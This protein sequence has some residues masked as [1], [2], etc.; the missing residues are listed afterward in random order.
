MKKTFFFLPISVFFLVTSCYYDVEEELYP[1]GCESVID[2]S[3]STHV[4]PIVDNACYGCHSASANQGNITLEG[5]QSLEPYLADG[6]FECS[7]NWNGGC[8]PM[9]KNQSK[10][11]PC[12]LAIVNQWLDDGALDN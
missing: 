2:V 9:P 6:S 12:D 1:E 3:Y 5:Y 4:L 11:H 8:S 10:M 7:I